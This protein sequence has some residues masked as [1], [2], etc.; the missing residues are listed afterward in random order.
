MSFNNQSQVIISEKSSE[1]ISTLT[2]I[3]SILNYLSLVLILVGTLGF[4]GNCL[5]FLHPTIRLHTCSIYSL[6]STISDELNLLINL[7]SDYV[8]IYGYEFPWERISSI[9]KL[10]MFIRVLFPQLSISFLILSLIDRFACSCDLT[11]TLRK[12]N[13]LKQVPWMIGLAVAYSLSI[14]IQPLFFY[15]ISPPPLR[16]CTA[17]NPLP[18]NI[19]YILTS[20]IAQLFLL[21]IFNLLL[22]KNVKR[23]RQR[24]V[25]ILFS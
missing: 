3:Q 16:T 14:G 4:V 7:L 23:S 21:L 2:F 20:T 13:Q 12:I 15:D 10:V 22:M 1:I 9:C 11:S 18:A 25:S 5:T 17:T 19:L 8:A 6:C 24:V